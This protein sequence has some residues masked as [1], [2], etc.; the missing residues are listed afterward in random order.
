MSSD[1]RFVNTGAVANDGTGDAIRTAFTTVNSN[2]S[3]IDARISTGNFGVVYSGTYIQA[4]LLL[5]SLGPTLTDSLEVYS[6]AN[7]AGNV[8]IANLTVNNAFVASRITSTGNTYVQDSLNVT[9]DIQVTRN[10]VI[11]GNLTVLGN[12]VTVSSADLAVQDSLINL[13]TVG[14][15]PLTFDDGKDI[16]LKFH[17]YKTSDKHAA[18]VWANDSQALEFYADGIE[19]VGNTFSGTYGNVKV[20]SLFVTNTTA[21]TD[22][23]TGAIV[24]RGGIAAAGNIAATNFLGNVYGTQANVANLSV[25][26]SV[27][28]SLYF[29]GADTIYINGSAVATS[30]ASF[31]GGTVPG[32]TLFNAVVEA[33]GNI[34][35]N[36][37]VASTS[38]T[39]G[40]LVVNGGAGISGTVY[41]GSVNAPIGTGT[42]N[43]GAFTTITSTGIINA[44]GN[45][46]AGATTH[47]V[48]ITT[49]ALVVKGGVGIAGNLYVGGS[50]NNTPIGVYGSSIGNFI[51]IGDQ[52]PG[53]GIFTR[54]QINNTTASANL[55]TGAVIVAGGVGVSGNVYAN[56][57]YA[58]NIGFAN[59][60]PFVSTAIANTA[61]ITA[62]IPSGPSVGVSLTTTGVTAGTYGNV[63]YYPIVTVDSKGRAT[64]VAS[65]VINLPLTGTSGTGAANG[66]L[67]FAGSSGV[68]ATVSGGTVTIATPQDVRTSAAPTF[69]G[70]NVSAAIVPTGNATVNLGS[71]TAWFNNIYGVSSQAK[72]ADLAEKYTSD[73]DYTPG[74][75]L[76]FGGAQEV[77]IAAEFADT[78]VAGAVTTDP[79]YLMNAELD[80]VAIALRGRIPVN[81]IGK[82]AK[83]DLLV[84]S[85]TPGCAVS[86]GNDKTYGPAVF[87]KALNNKENDGI[88]QIE[89]V[90]L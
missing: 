40:A 73:S 81:V 41:A 49:G 61:D 39:T 69:A 51:S 44:S 25:S 34:F 67:T 52:G 85:T 36:S 3:N 54:L 35:A 21:T 90:I 27:L 18:L 55:T 5:T 10:V 88:G 70:I 66:S 53:Y 7:I 42:A 32:Y 13:H 75:V 77:T 4:N 68:T 22:T 59:G 38:T 37:Q 45:I 89:A 63:T 87:A 72:Y 24:T 20:G 43:S 76:V 57:M 74:T 83:G 33:R 15:D 79:A 16:G 82:V 6:T 50:I 62:N 56:G 29:S 84:T 48:G 58:N 12:S 31:T 2:F 23:T 26:G 1:V 60:A 47:S 28:G 78:R 86:V 64:S 65:Q 17:Y 8:Q 9:N 71:P 11:G 30:A 80:G 14:L 19:S 46:V